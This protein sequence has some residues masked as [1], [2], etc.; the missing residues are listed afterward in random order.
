MGIDAGRRFGDGYERL[1][2]RSVDATVDF[3]GRHGAVAKEKNGVRIDHDRYRQVSD[4]RSA[5][6]AHPE[7]SNADHRRRRRCR[8]T[9]RSLRPTGVD[10]GRRRSADRSSPSRTDNSSSFSA[11]ER[12]PLVFGHLRAVFKRVSDSPRTKG[13]NRRAP[14][15]PLPLY[16]GVSCPILVVVW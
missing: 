15:P 11:V 5:P 6:I 16:R 2:R 3:W 12:V 8:R 9:D 1:V 4:G 14:P 10:H 7:R 13:I